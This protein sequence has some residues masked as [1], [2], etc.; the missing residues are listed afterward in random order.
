MAP[1][2]GGQRTGLDRELQR[3]GKAECTKHAQRVG[4]ERPFVDDPHDPGV[5][6]SATT[7][8]IDDRRLTRG[9]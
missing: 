9:G 4:G 8:G 2:D 7:E 5:Q 6:V 1:C 3:G